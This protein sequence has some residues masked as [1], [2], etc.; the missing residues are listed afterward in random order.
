MTWA[1]YI[2]L[3]GPLAP[4][5]IIRKILERESLLPSFCSKPSE[6]YL[7]PSRQRL[8]YNSASP[9]ALGRTGGLPGFCLCV[10]RFRSGISELLPFLQVL[11]VLPA[12][13]LIWSWWTNQPLQGREASFPCG[14]CHHIFTVWNWSYSVRFNVFIYPSRLSFKTLRISIHGPGPSTGLYQPG[15]HFPS[16]VLLNHLQFCSS[17]EAIFLPLCL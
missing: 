15:N 11:P 3:A 6:F 9:L 7:A 14:I 4:A 8:P 16:S 5:D 13:P 2:W 12:Q 1:D 17:Q 10:L